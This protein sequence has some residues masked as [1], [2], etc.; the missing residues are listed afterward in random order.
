MAHAILLLCSVIATDAAS[1]TVSKWEVFE[2]SFRSSRGYDNPP[3]E[4]RLWVAF[5]SPTGRT[6][7]VH[8]FWD[9]GS[10]WRVRF[11]PD[12]LG[13]WTYATECSDPR[14]QGLNKQKG[15]FV[16]TVQSLRTQLHR[17]GSLDVANGGATFQHADGTPFFWLS[18]NVA[19]GALQS[20]L[21]DWRVYAETRSSQGFNVAFWRA[22]PGTDGRDRA[23]FEGTNSIEFNR[24]LL[25]TLD[26]KIVTLNQSDMVSAIT[27]LWEIGVAEIDLLPEDQAI[28]LWRQLVARWDAFDVAWVIAF[29]PDTDGRRAARWRRIGRSVF[30]QVIHSP[31]ILFCGSSQWALKGFAQ[32]SWVDALAFQSGNDISQE[33]SLWLATGPASMLWQQEPIRPVLNLLPAMEAGVT[34]DHQVITSS[35]ATEALARSLFVAPPA[36][37]CYQCRAI[38]D[39]D[40]TVDTNTLATAGSEMTEW[41][42]SL[43]LP[44]AKRAA[45]IRGLLEANQFARMSPSASILLSPASSDIDQSPMTALVIPSR[46]HALIYVPHNQTA[47]IAPHALRGPVQG[48]FFSLLTGETLV[49][50]IQATD[51]FTGY[52]VPGPG[53]WLLRLA[54]ANN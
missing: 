40:Q 23:V 11:R 43:L 41:Q 16:C 1:S 28:V 44:G 3:Q 34:T 53:D 7:R 5:I 54:P 32:E 33:A 26:E 31:V 8:G 10:T 42:K 18:D 25:K 13:R 45:Q 36:G 47:R 15:E 46:D 39:W 21:K 48:S 4:V 30:D 24:G 38:S 27:P 49:A 9:G 12:E 2:D 51:E 35:E 29:E 50:E 19:V 52:S 37:L 20:S 17:H 6:N 22:S 14:N